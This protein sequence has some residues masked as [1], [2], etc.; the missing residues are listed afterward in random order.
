M[1]IFLYPK[2]QIQEE[3]NALLQIAWKLATEWAMFYVINRSKGSDKHLSGKI[4]SLCLGERGPTGLPGIDGARGPSGRDGSPG[5]Q[6]QKG[7]QG[8]PGSVGLQGAA[9]LV[10]LPVTLLIIQDKTICTE[11]HIMVISMPCSNLEVPPLIWY[12][13]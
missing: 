10:G 6:G 1:C 9:G 3:S 4:T 5:P 2:V 13:N 11:C 12:R 8:F 7:E